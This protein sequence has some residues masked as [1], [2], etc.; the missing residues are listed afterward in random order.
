MKKNGPVNGDTT[1]V[2]TYT[3]VVD[4]ALSPQC[5]GACSNFSFKYGIARIKWE[6]RT[7]W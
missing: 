6:I 5:V 3:V 2:A 7:L 1:S 4:M